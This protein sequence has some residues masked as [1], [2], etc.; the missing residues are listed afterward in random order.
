MNPSY[1]VL[2]TMG[3]IFVGMFAVGCALFSDSDNHKARQ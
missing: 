1:F 3:L 2:L